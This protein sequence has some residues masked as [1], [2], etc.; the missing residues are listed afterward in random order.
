[1]KVWRKTDKERKG[2]GKRENRRRRVKVRQEEYKKRGGKSRKQ[3]KR[4]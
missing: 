3:E 1:M 2:E 4:A